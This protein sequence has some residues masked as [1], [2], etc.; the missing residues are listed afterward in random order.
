MTEAASSIGS[1]QDS[2]SI[3]GA[4]N[5]GSANSC[6]NNSHDIAGVVDQYRDSSGRLDTG[7]MA[8]DIAET[9][10]QNFAQ[11]D[12][13]FQAIAGYLSE[14]GAHFDA[15]NLQQD[16]QAQFQSLAAGGLWAPNY[17]AMGSQILRDNPLLHIQWESTTSALTNR[18]GFSAPLE[19]VLRNSGIEVVATI[20]SP[21]PGSLDSS[22]PRSVGTKNNINGQLAS[23]AI[24][25]RYRGN[26]FEVNQ[27]VNYDTRTGQV[28]NA[29]R[30]SDA[31]GDVRRVDVEVRI[32]GVRTEMD[33]RILIESKVGY[34]SNGGHAAVEAANDARL[35]QTNGLARGAGT[36]LENFG[37]V[38]RPVGVAMDVYSLGSAYH[39]DGNQVGEN[40]QRTLSGIGGSVAGGAG[41]AWAGAAAGAAIGSVVPVVGTAVGAAVGGIIGGIAGGWG[42]DVAGK[43]LFDWFS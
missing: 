25:S 35:L 19:Q 1:Q 4:Q 31:I 18:S 2:S 36:V 11:A 38:A 37:K 34:T 29:T 30:S 14:T 12:A 22:D 13:G 17:K 5:S 32:P 3:S 15:A 6:A 16:V 43:A 10:Q 24:A 33:S 9:A 21:P 26:G 20:N 40:T 41:G 7:A 28:T 23:D 27:E 8:R 39:T 42:G